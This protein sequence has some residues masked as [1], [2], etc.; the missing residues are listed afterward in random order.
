MTRIRTLEFLPQIFQTET[1]SQF[2]G[3]TLDQLVNPP[4]TKK[5]QGFIGSKI[6]YGVDAKDYYVTEPNKVRKD[7]QLDP[8]VV[9]LKNNET[10]AKDFISYP[11]ILDALQQQGSIVKNNSDLFTSQFYS[12]DSFT[13][14]DKIINYN[15]Y[16]WIPTGPPAVSISASTVYNTDDFIVTPTASSYSIK[17]LG[18][19]EETN[20]PTL[21]LL[22]GGTYNFIVD[23]DSQFWIQGEPGLSGYSASQENLYV[24]DVF[25]VTNNGASQGVV[26]FTV[27][28]KNAQDEFN[29]PGNNTVGVVS[30]KP[31]SE[32]IGQPVG[33]GI[34]GV[35]FL[36]L[37]TVMFYNTGN[38]DEVVTISGIDYKVSD[39][40]FTIRT[41][42]GLLSFIYPTGLI[43]TE[44]KIT[45]QYGNDYSGLNF[46]KSAAGVITQ[47]PYLSAVLDTLYYQDGTNANRVGAIQL[48]ENNETNTIDVNNDILGKK[49][50]TSK[51]GVVFTN[52]LKV[53]FDGDV[54]PVSYLQGEYYVEGVGT[55]IELIPVESLN[56]PEPFTTQTASPFDILNYDIGPYDEGLNIP[57]TPDYI[58][59]ARNS[60]NKNAWS[61]SNRWFHIDV[62]NATA[63]YNNNPQI[64]VD[65]ALPEN[66]AKRPIIEFYPNL[67]LFNNGIIG[68]DNIDFLD[69]RTENAFDFVEGQQTYYPDVQTY[70]KTPGTGT[71]N[72]NATPIGLSGILQDQ[73]YQIDS[74]GNT[75]KDTWLNLG[76]ELDVDGNFL[77]GT[78][79]V[80]YGSTVI[81]T[82]VVAGRQYQIKEVGTTNWV[83]IGAPSNTVG[84]VFFATGGGLGTGVA[85]DLGTTTQDDWSI[86]AGTNNIF[87]DE[88]VAGVWYEIL[89]VGSTD[90]ASAGC[91]TTPAPGV[92]FQATGPAGG[93]GKVKRYTAVGYSPYVVDEIFTC[94]APTGDTVGDGEAFKLLF[95]A[96]GQGYTQNTFVYGYQY[97]IAEV[98]N[99]QWANIGWTGVFPQVGD[100]F[101]ATWPIS[102]GTT[103]TVYGTG[104]ATQGTGQVLQKTTTT[105]TIPAADIMSGTFSQGLWINDVKIDAASV[106]PTGTRILS[107][108]DTSPNFEMTVYWPIPSDS[109]SAS[110]DVS[111]IAN[112]RDNADLQLFPGARVV[113]AKDTN[114][115]VRN[116]IYVAE[117]NNTGAASFPVITLTEAV[118]SPVLVDDQFS[119]KNGFNFE[120]LVVYFNGEYYSGT[121]NDFAEAQQKTTVNQAPRFDLF[122]ENGIS[123]G[124]NSVYPS[125]TFDGCKLFNYKLG[126]GISDSVLGFPI[127]YSSINNVGDISFEISL[128]TQQFD[129]VTG[130]NSITSD[131]KNG[132]V[133]DYSSRT[134]YTRLTG[135]QTAVAQ[136]G[137]YQVFQFEY[138]ANNPPLILSTDQTIDYTVIVDVPQASVED[139]TWPSLQVFNNN[140]ILT[141]GTDY[142]VE[143]T[144][145]ETIITIKL[146]E[147]IDTPIQVLIL[148]NETSEN[149][150][151]T[152]PINLANNPFNT[153]PTTV[154]IGD[155]RG[156]YQ[157]IFQNNPDTTGPVFGPNNFRDLGNLVPWGTAIIQN[158]ASL[159]LPGAFL[160]DPQYNLSDALLFNS[161]EYIKFKNLLVD[162]VNQIAADQRFDPAILLDEA[163]DIITSVKNQEQPFFWSDMIPSKAPFASNTYN[164]AN[165]AEVSNFPLSKIYDFTSANYDGVLVYLQRIINGVV[166]TKQLLRGTEY[167]VSTDSPSVRVNIFL[168]ANDKITVKEYNQTYGSYV[169]NTP[170]KLGLYPLYEPKVL[171]DDTYTEPTYFIQGHDGSYNKL[172]GEYSE[173]YGMPLDFRDQALLEYETRVYNNIKLSRA[174]PIDLALTV[175]GYF[176]TNT[177]S[178]AEYTEIYSKNFLDWVGQNRLDYK[179]QLYRSNDEYS[180]NYRESTLKLDNS[181]VLQGYWRGIY[182]YVYDTSTPNLTPWAMIGYSNKPTWWEDRY[183]PAPYTNQNLILWT[184]LQDGIDY[185]G[186]APVVKP[187][188]A[189][190]GLLNIIPVDDQGNLK[191]PLDTLIAN[192]NQLTFKRDWIVGDDA[193]VEFSY[194]KSS[195]YPFDLMRLQSLLKP[196]DFYNLGV[197]LDNYKYDAEFNQFL[198]NGRTHLIPNQIAIYGNGTAKT[199]YINWIVDYT[200]QLGINATDNITNLL[201]N[202]D[203]RLVHRLAG[204][205]DKT[206]LKFF[207]EKGTPGSNNSSLMIPDESYQVL[208]YE[209]QPSFKL[210]YSGVVVQKT[211]N[212]YSVFGNS[213]TSAYFRTLRPVISGPKD[214]ITVQDLTVQVAKDHYETEVLVPYGTTYY[215]VND[216]SQFLMD[217]GAWLQSR[218]AIF[219]DQIQDVVINWNQMVA[220]FLYWTQ[221]GFAT[222]SVI[223]LNPAAK[224]LSIDKE[225]YI[226]QP[227]T[228]NQT[229]FVLNNNLY[230]IQ[231]KDLNIERNSTKFS[232]SPLNQGDAIGYGQFN[233]SNIEHGIV[234]QNETLF[235]D[236]IYNLVSGLRQSRIFVRGTKT[237]EWNGTV[238][239]SGFIY[240]QD[241]IQEWS[242]DL[243][244][245]RG[246]IVKYK[247]KYFTALEI[248]QPNP[249]FN[250]NQWKITDYDEIQ[251]GLLPNSST[252]SFESA[253]YYNSDSAN[254]ETDADL[255]AFSLIGFRPRDYMASADLTDITQVNVYKNLIKE[256]GT[257]NSVKAFKG[258]N[259]PQGG[260]DYDVYENWAILQGTFGGTLNDNFV[261]FK[262]NENQLTGNP[263]IVGL[264][265]GNDVPD[266]QQLVPLYSLYNYGRPITSPYVLPTLAVDTPNKVY[267]D[268]GY[269][270]INDVKM[271]AYFYS[272][273]P[274][275]VN[276]NG[277]IVP[278]GNLYVND[279]IWLADYQSN[280]KV[281]TPTSIGQVL[282]VRSNLNNTCTVTFK[283]DHNLSQ[284][285]IFAIIN[286]DT[287]VNGYFVANTIINP[288]QILITLALPGS[289]RI[290]T[291]QGIGLKFN[292]QRV[293]QPGDVESLP[294]VNTEFVKNR[295]WV[296]TNN[297]GS[298]A[299]YQK[300]INY[301]YDNE[302]YQ[303]NSINFGNAVAYDSD[304][305]YLFADSG[306]GNVYRYS[307]DVITNE[308][309][310]SE[311]LS[312]AA[313]FG[314]AVIHQ[315]N[316][317]VI[318]QPTTSPKL[319]IYTLNNTTASDE[320][321]LYQLI[322]ASSE[323][324]TSG[325]TNFGSSLAMSG[326]LNWLYV[327]DYNEATPIARNKVHVYRRRN[328]ETTAGSFVD[329]NTYQITELSSLFNA[330]TF[331]PGDT[332]T[333]TFVGDT[334]F[335]LLGASSNT[336]G[337]TFVATGTGTLGE[338]G[339]ARGEET[340]FTTIGAISNEVGIYFIADFTGSDPTTGTGTATR[341]D[342]QY[343]TTIN[344]PSTVV[345]KFGHSISTN[346]YGTTLVV[347]APNVDEGSLANYG[348]SYIYDRLVQNIEIN[349]AYDEDTPATFTLIWSPNPLLPLTVTKNGIL[350]DSS[351]YSVSGTTFTYSGEFDYGDIITIGG[352]EFVL[353][354]TLT[355]EQTP[356]IGV[357][358]GYS[359]DTNNFGTE[360][361][362][363]APFYLSSINAEGAVFRYTYGGAR[364]GTVIGIEEVDV[365]TSKQILINGFLVNIDAGDAS[366]AVAAINSANVPN[367]TASAQ[368]NRLVITLANQNLAN[369]NQ[370]LLIST[371]DPAALTELGLKLYTQTQIIQSPHPLGASQFGTV[372][373]FNEFNSV[374]ISAPVSDRYTLTTFDF[375]DDNINDN[376]T[377]FDNNSTQFTDVFDNAG[378]VYTFDYLSNYNESLNNIGS[379]TYG[380]SVN[381]KN[382][383]YGAQPTYGLALDWN[384]DRIVIGAPGFR[385][386]VIDG[387]V[388]TYIND[389]GEQNWTVYR[390]SSPVVDIDRIE[391]IQIF[392]AETNN[393]L[394]NLDYIDPLQGKILGAVRQNIDYI[395]NI[396][397]AGYNN[398]TAIT[399]N[400][401]WGADQVGKIWFDTANVRFLNYHQNDNEYNARYWGQLFPGSDVAVCT[402][403]ASNVPPVEYQ[404]PGTPKN[405]AA[406]TVQTALN[407]NNTVVPI[408]YFWARNTGVVAPNKNLADINIANYISN[409]QGSGISY[410]APLSTNIFG[411]YN[412][413]TYIN[414]NDSVLH[415]GFTSGQENNPAHQQF[416]LIRSDFADDFLPGVPGAFGVTEPESL[417]DRFLDSFTGVDESGNSVPDPFLPKAVQSGILARPRQSFFYNRFIALK[418]YLQYANTIMKLY[419]IAEIRSFDF[420]FESGTYYDTADYWEYIN[421]WAP[422]FDDNTRSVIQVPVY[423]D[424]ST[425][426]A[427]VGTIVTV[428]KNGLGLSETY[429]YDGDNVWTR[430]GLENGTIRFKSELYDYNEG[431]FGF[432][433][434]FYDTDSYDVFPSQPT[435]WI[436]RALNEQIYTNEL[437]IHRNKSLILM[438]EYIQEETIE[439]QNYLPWLNKTSLVD[440]S[441]K[442]RELKPLQNFISDN[443]EFLSGYVNETKPYHV[444]IK[445]FLFDYTGGDVY[446]G[447]ITDFDVPAEYDTNIDKF[448]SPQL[449]YNNADTD[450]EFLPD[451]PIWKTE[452][453]KEWFNN[454]GVSLTGQPDYLM[455]ELVSYVTLVSTTIVVDNAQGYPI[456]GTIKIDDEL[457][458]YASINRATGE[459]S[460]LTR[461]V[462]QTN[463]TVHL[464]GTNVFMDLPAIIVLD[465]GKNY[466]N[467]PRALAIIDTSKYPE[468][469]VQA[470]LEVTMSLDKVS[471]INVIN[472][473][474][475]YAVTPD[476]VIETAETFE[477]D[478]GNVN[479]ETSVITLDASTFVTGD[480]VRYVEGTTNIGG[481]A[482]NE[483]YYINVLDS[484][485]STII[486]LYDS[487][488]DAI[489]D[490]NR[491]TF[492]SQGTGTQSFTVGARA[493][494]VTSSSPVRENNIT[495]KFDRTSY[496]TQITDWTPNAFYASEFVGYYQDSSGSSMSLASTQPDINNILSSAGGTVFPIV[497]VSNNP[498]TIT[499]SDST[500]VVWSGFERRVASTAIS[501]PT[502]IELAVEPSISNPPGS[503]LGMTV[504]MPVKFSTASGGLLANTVYYVSSVSSL[505]RF[506]VS[507][508]P[509]GTPLTL[510]VSGPADMKCY[511]AKVTNAARITTA[512][513]GIRTV[514][515]TNSSNNTVIVPLNPIGT[516]GATGLYLNAPVI[517]TGNVFGGIEANKIYYVVSVMSPESFTISENTDST[518]I[519]VTATDAFGNIGVETTNGLEVGDAI[520]FDT[521]YVDNIA[522]ASFGGIS[523]KTIYYVKE[524]GVNNTITI[525]T[526]P[527]GAVFTTTTQIAGSGNYC[528]ITSQ[529]QVVDL[530]AASGSMILNISLPVSPGQV[531]G[532]K[533]TFYPSSNNYADITAPKLIYGN[534]ATKTIEQ[535]LVDN[536]V[537]ITGNT[538]QIYNGFSFT[539]GDNIGEL[540]TNNTYYAYDVGKI[541]F[542]CTLSAPSTVTFDAA[543]NG[544]VMTVSNISGGNLYPGSVFTGTE[545]EDNTYILSGPGGNGVYTISKPYLPSTAGTGLVANTGVVTLSSDY[546]TNGIY[547]GMPFTFTSGLVFGGLELDTDYYVRHI[548]N[549]STFTISEQKNQGALS[550]VAGAGSLT[551][552]GSA[553]FKVYQNM[554]D[555]IVNKDYQIK[556]IGTGN[557][558]DIGS[559]LVPAGS[560]IVGQ[561][562]IINS[563]G[564]TD[565]TAIGAEIN[566][567]DVI[568]E[569][570]GAGSGTGDAYV[571]SFTCNATAQTGDGQATV[572]LSDQS[573]NVTLTQEIIADPIFD[574]GYVLGGYN[575][576]IGSG[577]LGFTQN[578]TITILGSDLGGT[579]PTNDLTL[580]VSRINPIVPG[581]YSWSLPVESDGAITKLI[582]EGTPIGATAEYY[583]KVIDANT[584]EVY[585]DPLFQEPVS[586]DDFAYNG[587]TLTTS[588]STT[589]GNAIVVTS[590]TGFSV[591]DPVV[592]TGTT[593]P[594]ELEIGVVY[595]VES[596]PTSTTL[597]VTDNP[598][599]APISI[600]SG[601]V[602][603]MTVARAGSFMLLPEPFYFDPSIVRYNN[604]VY[605]CVVSNNDP[606]FVFGKWEELNAGDRRLNAL[607]RAEGW[608]EP[609]INM[610]GR[611][612]TQLFTG[613]TYPNTT[614]RGN[615]FNP[616][617]QYPLDTQLINESFNATNVNIPAIVFDGTNY[618]A[619][620][621]LPNYSGVIADI[622]IQNDWSIFKLANDTLSITDIAKQDNNYVMT[623]SNSAIPLFTS[624]DQMTWR[625]D[626]FFI[627][628]GIPEAV[629]EFYKV[630]MIASGQAFNAVTYH[631]GLWIAVNPSIATSTD[632]VTWQARTPIIATNT[633]RDVSYVQ[634]SG[635]DG[636]ITV[637]S[638]ATGGIIYR[639][640]D[641]LT[642][643]QVS[644]T[645][646]R[647]YN[648]VTS[649][650]GRIYAVGNQIISY[651][652]NGTTWTNITETGIVYN[653]VYFADGVLV[654]V[655]NNGII[656][657]STDGL[658]F[659]TVT[660]GVTEHLNSVIYVQ[661]KNEWTIVGNNNT[662]LQTGDILGTPVYWSNTNVFQERQSE[663][664]VQGDPFMFGY[665]PE[666]MVPG[667]VSDQLVMTVNTRPGT[668]WPANEY[669][670]VGYKVV[671]LELDLETSNEYDFSSATQTPA[672][673]NVFLLT[674][675]L[676]VTL[677]ENNDYTVD[678][679]NKVVTVINPLTSGQQLRIDVYEIG[680]GDQLV[681]SNTDNDPIEINITTGFDEISLDCNYT[682]LDYN[683][684]GIVQVDSDGVFYT[685]PAVFY[686]GQKLIP[687]LANY[688][689]ATSAVNN[690]ITV[691]STVGL[692]SDQ[693]I[694]FSDT[695]FGGIIP[696]TSYY[697]DQ[698]LSPTTLTIKDQFGNPVSVTSAT[699]TAVF[700]TQDYAAMIA[701]NQINAKIVFADH[702][703]PLTDY[704]SYSFF[705]ETQPIQYGYTVPQTQQFLGNGSVGPYTLTN[706]LEGD[707]PQNAIVEVNGE[708]VSTT[709]YNVN[710]TTSTLVF[711]SL[712]PSISDTIAVTT[713]N[714]TERQYLFTNEYTGQQ[715]SPIAFVNNVVIPAT[716]TTTIPHNLSDNDVVRIEGVQGSVQ[717]NG[718]MFTI[719]VL[720]A[721]QF[722][723]YEYIA[724]VP[725]TASVPLTD[726]NTYVSGGYVSP[727]QSYV[728]YNKTATASDSE[729][730][731]VGKVTGLVE[732]TP[733]YFTEDGIDLGVATSIPEIIAGQKYYIK[734]VVEI[735]SL[736]DKFSITETRNGIT[737]TLSVQSGLNIKVTQWEQANVDRL[738]VTVNGKRVASS[739][740]KLHDANE[741]CILTEVLPS[742]TVIIT[743]MMPSSTPDQQTYLQ[744]VN[745]AGQADVYRAN[746]ETRTWLREAVGEY[747]TSIKVG[748]ASKLTNTVTQES[749]APAQAFG[750]H[751]VP[752]IANRLDL[753]QVKVYNDTKGQYIDQDYLI[754]SSSGMGAFVSIQ[755]GSW[756][757]GNIELT[758]VKITDTTGGFSCAPSG[759]PLEV[760]QPITISG[761]LGGTGS[762]SGY[763]GNNTYYIIQTNGSTTFKLSSTIGGPAITTTAGTPT[764]LTYTVICG[765]NLTI[766]SLEG[767]LLYVNGEYMQILN[768]DEEANIISVQRGVLGSIISP[769]IPIYT[770][771]FSLLEYN[772]MTESNYISVWNPI[773]G[774]YNETKGDPLQIADTAGARFLKV[775]VT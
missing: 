134:E 598:G 96:T 446:P 102:L 220:E 554:G 51:N 458:S 179:T 173:V 484:T 28:E 413:K 73:Y 496:N 617:E 19:A 545:I 445:E 620:A 22:R 219:D 503:T 688:V 591:N 390:Q 719:N 424:L 147:D 714:D 757:T 577:G 177:L 284:Y 517:F 651:S 357:Q 121:V 117:F 114:L 199:S 773:P 365:T 707:N 297:D 230:P 660:S 182:E 428:S 608:Y 40:F 704:I 758:N 375:V 624:T 72:S 2:L 646:N 376:D 565:F 43:P 89:I 421:W 171:I 228:Y 450:Y 223:T 634:A 91:F 635:F 373:K 351:L 687:G 398:T 656:K 544:N 222:G 649:A 686:N 66:K 153:D 273:M 745:V 396:D 412:S 411:I 706:N 701:D 644:G 164:F 695:I 377:I 495:I 592:F 717:L 265:N 149:A 283:E 616:D 109:I 29:F 127:S 310:N 305:G 327:S 323:S 537:A 602:I 249:K 506:S 185:N 333:I 217:Y 596:T 142:T 728:L 475:G 740:L 560:F 259:L 360:I 25:G 303:T 251:K 652:T 584:L 507:A 181:I 189:R 388:V 35:T 599:G 613:L 514:T 764:G 470:E 775:D 549:S 55:A 108:E 615:D 394:I 240:N 748:D 491:I 693:R 618:I 306:E 36:N 442:I 743:S 692:E 747:S 708:R 542:V 366:V 300:S 330:G 10:T 457:I 629:K 97:T 535:T 769:N 750:Y 369:I 207:V 600:A 69:N 392:S 430:I 325:S 299:V 280:W 353:V 78:E 218:G 511:T 101:T 252:R 595:Y 191:A 626:S 202:L 729:F 355:N 30:T 381:A 81:A 231:N 286:F 761:I 5:I 614:Y 257:L 395:S 26:T 229:N 666:E 198:V 175:P 667:I 478:S 178:Y 21:T 210:I 464:P 75:Q 314:T 204:F 382:L 262:L 529:S 106:L 753:I 205:S 524:I 619:P 250:Q 112:P 82:S 480:M 543:F 145:T 213:Q 14:L 493:L 384:E 654:L 211:V 88:I 209:N 261:E 727:H 642:W 132:F 432:G 328:I 604:R 233:L 550:L 653:D 636:Y 759:Q 214:K 521:M 138:T 335:T 180:Y 239:A 582:T 461:G 1:N 587:Y 359:L 721:T 547:V 689:I 494:A 444:V 208:L 588:T 8:G 625:T 685:E 589:T 638:T 576:L 451:S 272:N 492:L 6:G 418:N 730:I 441:H 358:F 643:T 321:E 302:Y 702:Y 31:Y 318:S 567:V 571:A 368:D 246:E 200:K 326:D 371:N 260:I 331:I 568:F 668:N 304:V 563:V 650:F 293:A 13:D 416:D 682:N 34:D 192:Y 500:G 548:I 285:D 676:S 56:V 427:A 270:N 489:E 581:T 111:F 186:G 770:T 487:Y 453:Y 27:P 79:Y 645:F 324:A 68:K 454:Y 45:V 389:I 585:N 18:T 350:V 664:V 74:L 255:L 23:Q 281:L 463:I 234:F 508:T 564:T 429:I 367:V 469:R 86:I 151:Y 157:S 712:A 723:L 309:T 751:K 684:G 136:S 129:Y 570:T 313:S 400:L 586:G 254:L 408:Y 195:T 566:A 174:L 135:W 607:D 155:I 152:I 505:T 601:Q 295:V 37:R 348:N 467:P 298:W 77:T 483:Y 526:T 329:G 165:Q 462:N 497:S 551:A 278:L 522:V 334:D 100:I 609:S 141:L 110:T 718:Q 90:W 94:G 221:V 443:Q 436:I 520:V 703:D 485:P 226:V 123:Y 527:G 158:S 414:A 534:L 264:T 627:P 556:T 292:S 632:L 774:I 452:K 52:G 49:N 212:G 460:G 227:L 546:N 518:Y 15:Q 133:Y 732:G 640:L 605:V 679:Y 301:L 215:T 465:G 670:H 294:L 282:Q 188:Y 225:N 268:A 4:V 766:T 705:G 675:G 397:P 680:N 150:Y 203:V 356:R 407:S 168:Q 266:A 405:V 501:G 275:A 456:N 561:T 312:G 44:Q 583:L 362:V 354:Q 700:V 122:D 342:Y 438:F 341:C 741:V 631:N 754:L 387:Q 742:D 267:P 738:W 772:K 343:M 523:P 713:Y 41:F 771:V 736:D 190:P 253:L 379:Y 621:N 33:D 657:R 449:V 308:Y 711:N 435:R 70:T 50:Y 513:P 691:F 655:G 765:D 245:T 104:L 476:I 244:Y 672:Q 162:T 499:T 420:L 383:E 344:G 370:E 647:A 611:D 504:N 363:G 92:R 694:T 641:G 156:Q 269:V 466:A 238:F 237:A 572:I 559:T 623:S 468:P 423:A 338:T 201:N 372:V 170:T 243:K 726:I 144:A 552:R 474:E 166:V 486:A 575:V 16:Y 558:D 183:G 709:E 65:L 93:T 531:N 696:L 725:Y 472:P 361:L 569:A 87:T 681:K 76:A 716:V 154:D 439:N 137:Q 322:S 277:I 538:S 512:Y 555:L 683:G 130:G 659:T 59:I 290:L 172:Y 105:V 724:D 541:P 419:P 242:G 184:D 737:K 532:Q 401:V 490:K 673:I 658:T 47:I 98:G 603:N 710:Y 481:L 580:T 80:I 115:N 573:G 578:N 7:Y 274:T 61:R 42:G 479:V 597:V 539:V 95:K 339:V 579:S 440:V 768:V 319:E 247:N 289:T 661:E 140:D 32:L 193:P 107:I 315:D 116:K 118:D 665:G 715:V 690:S 161:R 352:S 99:T 391:N 216:V 434:T 734:Q 612:L 67:R 224:K 733:V 749:V 459:L 519:R 630:K 525:S 760:G 437:L 622:E 169:P 235:N 232:V 639:S 735:D 502:I 477:F 431:G 258:A 739:N 307:L 60:I 316:L 263:G 24:R 374:A 143:N 515:G 637:G 291:G 119:V 364:F 124:N 498:A 663:Y 648:A 71:V 385:P 131:V 176:R 159:V 349:Q 422:G 404:G 9:F 698:V 590:T 752:L 426:D 3:A 482:N 731:T 317:Y 671:S 163:I 746:T 762:I 536:T 17:A 340:V 336:V 12:W 415:V 553:S 58:T 448:V 562:Y 678:W 320:L 425:L 236:V 744:I 767:K 699:G 755:A 46:Y 332:Y 380:Q 756:I 206:L 125:T 187:L 455:G 471:T 540:E 276:Q 574:I 288:R 403:V 271:S 113:F 148:S 346:H 296:D 39:Y 160:R 593:L 241:N 697:I 139:T 674:D 194:R 54:I 378:A 167:V 126:V 669:G 197:D 606:T 473:G 11:G 20:N 447:T 128:Y 347:G 256:K 557:W 510:T 85:Y 409:P 103:L 662:V 610:P 48:I 146:T 311:T 720:S 337:V 533:F 287:S 402:W 433:G 120:G 628:F 84:V 417:Y 509:N 722:A 530:S 279:Y 63:D 62:I 516:G 386:T 488:L 410:L 393:T 248:I 633:L 399:P 763:T 53:E 38:P 677:Y 83:S 196:A 594:S 528:F 406:F 57:T 64:A 345:D